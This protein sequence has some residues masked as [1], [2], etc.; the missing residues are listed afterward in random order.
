[1]CVIGE[2]GG[3]ERVTMQR[4]SDFHNC[5]GIGVCVRRGG[6]RRWRSDIDMCLCIGVSSGGG[7]N[8]HEE[9]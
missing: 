8:Q 7:G 1:V 5:P 9:V 4:E 3:A 6:G 2:R